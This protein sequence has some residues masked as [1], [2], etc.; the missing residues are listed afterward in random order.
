[1]KIY[2]KC[3]PCI[4]NQALKFIDVSCSEGRDGI[5]N[6][7]FECMSRADY[8][9]MTTPELVG[10]LFSLVTR[11]TGVADP[12]K[13]IRRSCNELLLAQSEDFEREI[14]SASDPF[15]AAV[16]Y[17]IVGNMVDFS[18]DYDL[19]PDSIRG[20]FNRFCGETLEIDDTELLKKDI[21][22]AKTLVYLGDN[23]GEICLDKLLIK[24]I[25][26]I[27]PE[28][29]IYF[30][31]K[32]SPAVNDSVYEDAIAVGMQEYAAVTD[33]GD[34]SLGTV[35][36]RVSRDFLEIFNSA[37]VIISKGQANYECLDDAEGN[38]YF[39]LMAKCKVIAD[40]L[41]TGEMKMVCRKK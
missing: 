15:S 5:I 3:L 10:E 2:K 4:V 11:E 35:L 8:D 25:G 36:G 28:C 31:T 21:M 26:E 12:Y 13:D 39:L 20:F 27:N 38:I 34:S 1:M 37:D 9:K 30:V 7:I 16:K 23:C 29:R 18:H 17:S 24:K 32:G 22:K 14:D 6:K 40:A 19:S 41:G 33:N